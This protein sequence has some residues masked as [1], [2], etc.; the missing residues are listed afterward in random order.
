MITG[1]ELETKAG[2]L[3]F[4]ETAAYLKGN[5]KDLIE[6]ISLHERK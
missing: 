5:G 1:G 4:C 2:A 6:E 3:P